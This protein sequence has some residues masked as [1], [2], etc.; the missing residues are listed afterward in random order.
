MP[1]YIDID[2][3]I[4]IV[5]KA[6]E[7]GEYNALI[8]VTNAL[9]EAPCANVVP[10]EE[11]DEWYHEYHVIKD[12]LKTEKMYHRETEK[13]ADK[14]FIECKRLEEQLDAAIAG[15]ETL[16]RYLL[17]KDPRKEGLS[18]WFCPS[19]GVQIKYDSL[20]MPRESAPKY[21]SECGQK[22]LW[23]PKGG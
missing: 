8:K 23:N 5:T 1:R 21:C 12:A 10:K 19:C 7:G 17:P 15:Q 18:D 13:L 2:N 4:K 20:N 6:M 14:Y 3:A 16:Q 11:A 9:K 22:L